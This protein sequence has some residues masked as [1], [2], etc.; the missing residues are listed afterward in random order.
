M[1][2]VFLVLLGLLLAPSS[3]AG[4]L[5]VEAWTIDSSN[6]RVQAAAEIYVDGEAQ[7][8]STPAVIRDLS[9]GTHE[10]ELRSGC[11]IARESVEIK[12]IGRAHLEVE[13]ETQQATLHIELTPPEAELQ[14]D[15]K[16]LQIEPNNGNRLECGEHT[17]SAILV[18]HKTVLTNLNLA[19]GEIQTVNIELIPLGKG[20]VKVEVE[21][22]NAEV[23][24]DGE[25]QGKGEMEL[26]VFQG[27][28]VVE[29]RLRGHAA[30]QD[31]FFIMADEAYTVSLVLQP[32]AADASTGNQ[33]IFSSTTKAAGFGLSAFG[34]GIMVYGGVQFLQTMN[35]Y[36]EYKQ[37]VSTVNAGLREPAYAADF[38][39][40]EVATRAP[41]MRAALGLGTMALSGGL[42]MAIRF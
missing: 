29:A 9:Q 26:S 21:P 35:A 12:K 28:H 17:L 19:P 2:R 6:H 20:M 25:T 14:L 32:E 34:A 36:S 38:Y 3:M 1:F 11:A 24:L 7:E 16:E 8:Q 37:R 40:A 15:G 22:A 42:Y 18:G 27:P 39:D 23:L 41:R 33:P 13:L 5:R 30:R 10:V 31:T 4:E